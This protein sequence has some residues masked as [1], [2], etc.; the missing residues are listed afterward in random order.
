LDKPVKLEAIVKPAKGIIFDFDGVLADSEK[1]HFLSYKEVFAGYG[2]SVNET[3]YYKYWTSLGLGAKGEIDRHKLD[4]D[5]ARIIEEKIPIFSRYCRDG[6]IR[7]YKEAK[8][9]VSLFAKAGKRMAVASGSHRQD[10]LAILENEGMEN[11]FTAINGKESVSKTKPDPEVFLNSAKALGLTKNECVVFEDAEKGMFAALDAGIPVVVVKSRE[12]R[13]F[14]F[15]QADLVLDSL[16]EL[17]DL[18][19]KFY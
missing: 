6:S 17:L 16:S 5:P 1:Y 8:E 15:S 7:L 10:I 14:D 11:Y 3:E 2:H 12:T 13:G 4:I 18:L 19:K 9:I